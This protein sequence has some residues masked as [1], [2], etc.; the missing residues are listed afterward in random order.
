MLKRLQAV[1]PDPEGL[2][3]ALDVALT[4]LMKSMK[5]SIS[6]AFAPQLALGRGKE[7]RVVGHPTGTEQVLI[8]AHVPVFGVEVLEVFFGE[9]GDRG[10]RSGLG[11]VHQDG[12]RT[13]FLLTGPGL[14]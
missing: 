14:R 3:L 13:S 8:G 1:V 7:L 4:L 5:T 9:G 10:Q 2:A 11:D 6:L 12:C